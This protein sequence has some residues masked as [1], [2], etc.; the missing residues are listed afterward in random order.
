MGEALENAS[1]EVPSA[2]ERRSAVRMLSGR[3]G[4]DF[5]NVLEVAARLHRY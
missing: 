1:P 5:S 2:V 4:G 3:P